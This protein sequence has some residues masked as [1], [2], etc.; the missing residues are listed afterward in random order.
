[1]ATDSQHDTTAIS[2]VELKHFTAREFNDMVELMAELDP[3][4]HLT[5][6][7]LRNVAYDPNSHLYTLRH[8][9]RIIGC[10]V[11]AVFHS[12]TGRK[13]SIEDVT[14]LPEYQGLGLGR[15]LVEHALDKLQALS[16]IHIQLTSRPS[17]IAANAMYKKMGFNPKETN[18]YT[19][20]LKE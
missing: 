20:D 3:H 2:I 17:R 4:C 14:V 19:L 9:N 11:A 16:P 6:D 15:L 10:C 1:M 18:V 5:T 7:M 12:P 13:A 8:A